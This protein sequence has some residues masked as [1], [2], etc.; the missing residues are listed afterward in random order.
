MSTGKSCHQR[1]RKACSTHLPVFAYVQVCKVGLYSFGVKSCADG[2]L[3]FC[4]LA[5]GTCRASL[6]RRSRYQHSA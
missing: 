6:V 2:S 3:I 4:V 1:L 5:L